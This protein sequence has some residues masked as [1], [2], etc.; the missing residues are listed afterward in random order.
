MDEFEFRLKEQEIKYSFY[1]FLLGTFLLGFIAA[2]TNHQIQSTQLALKEKEFQREYV[3]KFIQQALES[4]M[5][6]RYQ[7]AHYFYRLLGDNWT[8]YFSDIEKQMREYRNSLE[9]KQKAVVEKKKEIEQTLFAA[10]SS[11]EIVASLVPKIA[12]VEILQQEVQHIQQQILPQI[13][14]VSNKSFQDVISEGWIYLGRKNKEVWLEKTVLEE[15]D[16]QIGDVLTLI[17]NTYLRDEKP[18]RMLSVAGIILGRKVKVLPENQK[19]IVK[20]LWTNLLNGA[21]WAKITTPESF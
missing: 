19:V 1:K 9:E 4:N 10:S 7:F 17:T 2:I 8:L 16:P 6:K 5:E 20:E 18:T 15:G 11:T 12:Q 13:Q 21:V 3:S 14:S